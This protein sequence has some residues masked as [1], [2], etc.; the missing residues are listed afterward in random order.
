MGKEKYKRRIGAGWRKAVIK[1]ICSRFDVNNK[2]NKA[3]EKRTSE[4]HLNQKRI[5]GC[6][7]AYRAT[8]DIFQITS[9]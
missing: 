3:R 5:C 9:R 8:N 2:W 1:Y 4:I 7:R 6:A